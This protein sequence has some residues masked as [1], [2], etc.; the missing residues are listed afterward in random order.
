VPLTLQSKVKIIIWGVCLQL[1]PA[2]LLTIAE[3]NSHQLHASERGE[4][5]RSQHSMCDKGAESVDEGNDD[6]E[7]AQSNH[8][9]ASWLA[10]SVLPALV[11]LSNSGKPLRNPC[12]LPEGLLCAR[13]LSLL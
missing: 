12:A 10:V 1:S 3:D 13:R 8:A 2:L 9:A 5:E 6:R 4:A 11:T 7:P